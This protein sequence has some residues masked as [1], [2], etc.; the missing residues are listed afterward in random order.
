M[1]E[2]NKLD[3]GYIKRDICMTNDINV[4]KFMLE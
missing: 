4:I 2:I 3:I 1:T